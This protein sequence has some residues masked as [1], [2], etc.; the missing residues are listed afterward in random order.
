M[1]VNTIEISNLQDIGQSAQV[2][3]EK[4]GDHKIIAF[5][6]EMGV[7][8][9]TFIKALCRALQVTD[10]VTSPTFA[11]VNEYHTTGPH[12]I[13]HFDF[14]RIKDPVEVL[15]FGF[16]E[17]VYSGHYCFMEWPEMAEGMLPAETLKVY[18]DHGHNGQRILNF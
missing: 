1:M 9:T 18:L 4:I 11:I 3:L 14:Y 7:G 8:K 15:D 5:Y 16:D 13:F 17:Y 10:D 12:K 2:F 6:G